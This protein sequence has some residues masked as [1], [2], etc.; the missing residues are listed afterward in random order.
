[1]LDRL[2]CIEDLERTEEDLL[3]ARYVASCLRPWLDQVQKVFSTA[4]SLLFLL[5]LN[6]TRAS[7]DD[8][9][10]ILAKTERDGGKIAE[11]AEV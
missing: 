3:E 4:Q 6:L 10:D 8:V 7:S 5:Q 11:C 9:P 1:M 2:L